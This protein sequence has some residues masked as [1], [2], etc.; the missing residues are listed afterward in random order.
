MIISAISKFWLGGLGSM[1]NYF[2]CPIT[3]NC[4]ITALQSDK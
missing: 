4:P 3:V 2:N 1:I